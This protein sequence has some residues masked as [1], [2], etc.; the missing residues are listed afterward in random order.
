[1]SRIG[2]ETVDRI[3]DQVCWTC[4]IAQVVRKLSYH[5]KNVNST[6]CGREKRPRFVASPSSFIR[7][8]SLVIS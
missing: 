3:G 4:N 6:A 1:M 5:L 7:F 2:Y 8:A